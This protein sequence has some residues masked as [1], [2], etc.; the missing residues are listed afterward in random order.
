MIAITTDIESR[1]WKRCS[2]LDASLP[3][4]HPR[5][6]TT[7]DVECFFIVLRDMVGKHFTLKEVKFG[8]RKACVEFAKRLDP[9]LKFYYHTSTHD[10]FYEGP[11]PDFSQFQHPKRNPRHQ[12]VRRREQP[13][14]LI[15]G[16][17]SL[18]TPSARSIRMTYHNVPLELPPLPG[19]LQQH[20]PEQSYA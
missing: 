8:W 17:A 11:M 13:S 1:E 6:S 10:R 9:D 14:S 16:R 5:A 4:E 15:S 20:L 2:N 18:A 12:R 19:S 3:P 7:D